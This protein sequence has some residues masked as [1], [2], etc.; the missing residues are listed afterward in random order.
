MWIICPSWSHAYWSVLIQCLV[1]FLVPYLFLRKDNANSTLLTTDHSYKYVSLML[2]SRLCTA[3]KRVRK[4]ERSLW[5]TSVP[6][7]W[8]QLPLMSCTK[9][10]FKTWGW[11]FL[12]GII[13]R[14]NFQFMTRPQCIDPQNTVSQVWWKSSTVFWEHVWQSFQKQWKLLLHHGHAPYKNTTM[15]LDLEWHVILIFTVP[16]GEKRAL[17]LSMQLH[18]LHVTRDWTTVHV[19]WPMLTWVCGSEACLHLT[20][21]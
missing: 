7:K 11:L 20:S 4:R 19:S 6:N 21:T 8:K 15:P 2:L 17:I 14:N 12:Y 16:L 13:Q 3:V 18:D 1:Q 9:N 5:L 10:I